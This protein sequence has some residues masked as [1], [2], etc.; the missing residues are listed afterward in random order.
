MLNASL[1]LSFIRC[2]TM[3]DF[4]EPDGAQNMSSLPFLLDPAIA[5]QYVK[6]LFL[7]AL[8]F[9]LHLYYQ[10]LDVHMVGF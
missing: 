9:I 5:L 4:P 1:G 7:D 10:A 8:K 6:N 2:C 3:V